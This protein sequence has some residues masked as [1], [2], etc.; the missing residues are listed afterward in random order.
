MTSSRR[1]P[2]T[3][4]S[5]VLLT[6]PLGLAAESISAL[7]RNRWQISFSSRGSNSA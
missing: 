3:G 5:I 2:N 6:N 1:Y 4:T 7:Y